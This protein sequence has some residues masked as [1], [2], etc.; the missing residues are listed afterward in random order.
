MLLKAEG[1]Y[2]FGPYRLDARERQL[3]RDGETVSLPPKAFDVLVAL[4]ARAGHLVTKED[5]LAEV[6]PGTFVEDANIS[7]TISLV[8]R[9]LREEAD[10]IETVP[11]VGYRF[12]MP[13]LLVNGVVPAIQPAATRRP[14]SWRVSR[15]LIAVVIL[16]GLLGASAWIALTSRIAR[17]SFPEPITVPVTSFGGLAFNPR[18]SPDGTRVVYQWDGRRNEADDPNWDIYVQQVEGD[19]PLR[20]TT[21]P[22]Q[23]FNP[24]W[25]P[26]ATKVA[27]LRRVGN[28]Y[29]IKVI[30]VAGGPEETV[31]PA[32]LPVNLSRLDWAPDGGSLALTVNPEGLVPRIALLSIQDRKVTML[33]APPSGG[34][35]DYNP[36]FSPDG[37]T[38]AFTRDLNNAGPYS[39]LYSIPAKGGDER[40]LTSGAWGIQGHD[41]TRD[42]KELVFSSNRGGYWTLWR[43]RVDSPLKA[44][45]PVSG[46]GNDAYFPSIARNNDRLAYHESRV[47]VDIWRVPMSLGRDG[48]QPGLGTPA[49]VQRSTRFDGNPKV[50]R[51]G[52]RLVFVSTRDGDQ[53]IWVSATDGRDARRIAAF[54]GYPAGSPRWSPSGS[55]VAFDAAVAGNSNIFVVSAQGGEPT[56]LTRESGENVV[57]CWSRDE[58]WIYFASNRTGRYE[59]WKV[60]SN[61]GS[62]TQVTYGGGFAP[63]ESDDGKFIYYVKGFEVRGIWRIPVEGGDET[64][65]LDGPVSGFWGYWALL[66]HG[67]VFATQEQNGRAHALVS[68]FNFISKQITDLGHLDSPAFRYVPNFAVSPDEKWIYYVKRKQG[69]TSDIMLVKNFR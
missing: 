30:P 37:K 66:P 36:R 13:V 54:H 32:D 44:P 68:Y 63:F 49:T 65:I 1:L 61:G 41:W 34:F 8:R 39:D 35:G 43:L 50:S 25:S 58:K 19:Q 20:L 59:V 69:D 28:V 24:V 51:D 27:F 2:V 33:T 60:S 7:Y 53:A 12:N 67:I 42:G 64:R 56:S 47:D 17:N 10:P 46:V 45:Q 26:D 22:I 40:Q 23:E 6:W 21:D 29:A 9:A 18:L 14:M 16:L 38:I 52:S 57:P 4:V 11:K 15:T 31:S 48:T 5:L 62:A 3:L 55:R